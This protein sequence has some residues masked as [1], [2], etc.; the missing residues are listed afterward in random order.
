MEGFG[1]SLGKGLKPLFDDSPARFRRR[2][3][4]VDYLHLKGRQSGDLY[5][6]RDGWPVAES[7]LPVHWFIG[8][9]FCKRGRAL[10]GA[11]GAVY[12]VPVPH[13]VRK[14]YA[15]VVKFSRFGQDVG[16]TAVGEGVEADIQYHIDSA[17]FLSPFQEFGNVMKLRR[18]LAGALRTQ[19]PLAIYS[20]PTR[21]LVWE[22]GRKPHLQWLQSR[23]LR[24][25]QAET[26][27]EFRV[28]YAWERLYIL[29]YRW[30]DGFDAEQCY[31]SGM[32]SQRRM[33]ELTRRTGKMLRNL[34][35]MVLD[36]KPRHLILRRSG[37]GLLDRHGNPVLGLVDYEL[38]TPYQE[39]LGSHLN[40]Q[41]FANF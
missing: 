11:T 20:P 37:D 33:E 3:A 15:L 22:L 2:I 24:Q 12:R 25:S 29:L 6:T 40:I 39:P 34:G 38:L 10:A 16:I 30:M 36:H 18:T 4:G 14:E 13:P 27:E 7:L 17:E 32:I 35:W 26:S 5:I 1:L 19:I 41:H 9:Q 28:T 8:Q 31:L 23:E 21:H